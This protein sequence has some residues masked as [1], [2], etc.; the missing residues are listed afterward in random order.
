MNAFM[1]FLIPKRFQGKKLRKV[2]ILK[3]SGNPRKKRNRPITSAVAMIH[4]PFWKYRGIP[5]AESVGKPWRSPQA[6]LGDVFLGAKKIEHVV[7]LISWD[8]LECCF[9][10]NIV[11]T[12]VGCLWGAK[13]LRSS[14]WCKAS[15]VFFVQSLVSK[16]SP[17]SGSTE[18]TLR[19]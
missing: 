3:T 4:L 6:L 14:C 17:T 15:F 5:G 1:F 16:K 10:G 2:T 7:F 18:R 9:V 13:S 11:S 12:F 8:C 19:P